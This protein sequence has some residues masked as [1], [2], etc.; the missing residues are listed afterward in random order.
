MFSSL[1]LNEFLTYTA[2]Q[3]HIDWKASIGSGLL[4]ASSTKDTN[5]EY[6]L[7]NTIYEGQQEHLLSYFHA[8]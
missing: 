1:M 4:K 6:C 8:S 2:L 5:A 7:F 3:I